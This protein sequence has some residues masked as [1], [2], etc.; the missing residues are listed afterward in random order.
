MIRLIAILLLSIAYSGQAQNIVVTF[1]SP[2][3]I[4]N[5]HVG[6]EWYHTLDFE[7]KYYSI[8]EPL[9]ITTTSAGKVKIYYYRSK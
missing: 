3:E 9:Q 6:H 1:D 8:N 5:D 2:T 7:G 4:Y